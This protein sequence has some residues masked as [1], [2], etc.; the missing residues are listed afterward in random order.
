MPDLGREAD[1][2]GALEGFRQG[3]YA[4]SSRTSLSFK[5]RTV[6]RI[7]A[8]WGASPYPISPNKVAML[9]AT[10]KAGG[11]RSAPG[12]LSLYAPQRRGEATPR[13]PS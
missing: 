13:G 5:W 7:F 9:G 10:L 12:Y 2:E 8:V 6:E 1:R 4:E 11:Y 3:I